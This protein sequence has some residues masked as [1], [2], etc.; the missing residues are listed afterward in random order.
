M[1]ALPSPRNIPPTN[2]CLTLFL[3]II[4]ILAQRHL[5]RIFSLFGPKLT[6]P[7]IVIY[8]IFPVVEFITISKWT[9]LIFNQLVYYLP[10]S[11]WVWVPWELSC[12][13]QYSQF[14]ISPWH[15]LDMA[16]MPSQWVNFRKKKWCIGRIL[17]IHP[18]HVVVERFFWKVKDQ[19]IGPSSKLHSQHLFN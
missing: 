5:F 19:A 9:Y 7:F 2:L 12:S 6:Y 16:E 1:Y 13:A 10:F 14:L 15:I 18:D 4:Q 11:T 3:L 17:K 8:Y